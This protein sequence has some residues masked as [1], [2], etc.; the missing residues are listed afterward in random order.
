MSHRRIFAPLLVALCGTSAAIPA[1][2]QSLDAAA[3]PAR[4]A[5]LLVGNKS[6]ASV[7]RLDLADG[8]KLG[9]AATGQGPHEIAVAPGGRIAVVAD[10]GVGDVP[11]NTLTVL[12]LGGG[13][14]RS[15]DLGDNTRPHGL[16]FLPGGTRLVATAEGSD[17]LVVVDVAAGSVEG[18]IDIGPGTGHMVA[19]S[20][21]GGIA[22]VTKVGN[23]GLVR[24]DLAAA[25]RDGNDDA[26]AADGSSDGFAAVRE[27]HAGAGAEGIDV[28]PDG[29]VWV[30]NREAGTVTVHDP[31]SLA[32]LDT[33]SSP[34]FPIRLV[35][36]PDGRHAL[37]TNARA[38]TLTVFDAAIRK[39]VATVALEPEGVE[40]HD[41]ML[42]RAA[43]PI[44][45]IAD[46][47]GSRV[48]VAVSGADRVAV[49]DTAT[50][51][52]AEYW[53][54]G[55]EPDALGIVAP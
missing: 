37:V 50:W 1:L 28:A 2:A 32:V 13:A 44:G 7:W 5:A 33:L 51:T 15:I 14:A 11:G 47:D 4:K 27:I 6:A 26:R 3:G 17:A 45:A 43:L 39:P 16:R 54:T 52:V 55:R 34:G 42:G 9:E 24:V 19:L 20:A 49:I 18:V 29:T 21:D 35:F 41:T 25:G 40:L 10:Y 23:G 46:P 48:F 36:T 22:Y 8:A 12:D 31:D 38:A 53:E 30:S